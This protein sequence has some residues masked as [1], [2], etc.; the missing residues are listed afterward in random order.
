MAQSK[1]D[2]NRKTTI[3]G[4]SNV[5]KKTPTLIASNPVTKALLIELG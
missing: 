3:I 5:D 4:V 2:A 1:R